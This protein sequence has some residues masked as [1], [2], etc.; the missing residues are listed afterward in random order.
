M[1]R[2]VRVRTSAERERE[3]ERESE[4]ERAAVSKICATVRTEQDEE[5]EPTPGLL[6]T[7]YLPVHP[8]P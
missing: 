3:S 1:T 5:G 8:G 2:T 7:S 6:Y 4:R